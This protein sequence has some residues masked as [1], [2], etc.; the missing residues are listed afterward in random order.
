M[1]LASLR[2]DGS[3]WLPASCADRQRPIVV[4]RSP[5]PAARVSGVVPVRARATD[6]RGVVEVQL[7]V[8]GRLLATRPRGGAVGFLWDTRDLRPGSTHL[9]EV[10][11][12]DRCGNV[13][14]PTAGPVAVIVGGA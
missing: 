12:R 7:W 6:D 13:G 4:L 9:L 10:V 2:L 5:K 11:A 14:S 1:Q 3:Q 8:D